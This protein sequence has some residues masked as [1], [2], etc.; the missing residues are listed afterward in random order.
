MLRIKSFYL[1]VIVMIVPMSC[2]NESSPTPEICFENDVLPIFLTSCTYSGCHN[3]VDR[4]K[5]WDLT[6]YNGI[7]R[8]INPGNYKSSEMYKVLI[9]ANPMPPSPYDRLDHDQLVTIASWIEQGAKNTS[10]PPTNCDTS[11]VSLASD[12]IPILQVYCGSCHMVNKPQ[13]NVDFRT[14]DD[15]R[16]Y[17]DDNSLIGSIKFQSGFSAMPKNSNKIPSCAINTIESWV[18]NGAPNN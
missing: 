9:S 12:V 13:G 2:Q 10:C 8:G 5:G 7:I 6:T 3:A 17:V 1:Y 11:N 16:I 15:L 18:R 14:Y 4:E